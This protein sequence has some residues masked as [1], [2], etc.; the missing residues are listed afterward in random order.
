MHCC[1]SEVPWQPNICRPRSALTAPQPWVCSALACEI[2]SGVID[3]VHEV[4]GGSSGTATSSSGRPRAYHSAT[5]SNSAWV[6]LGWLPLGMPTRWRNLR[7][8]ACHS[9][10]ENAAWNRFENQPRSAAAE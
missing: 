4:G 1:G 5:M 10:G 3:G 7:Y 8:S 2:S 6:N 9:D